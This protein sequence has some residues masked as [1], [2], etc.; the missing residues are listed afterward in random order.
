M[1]SSVPKYDLTTIQ[2]MIANGEY[3][4]TSSAMRDAAI[5]DYDS[6]EIK[7]IVLSLRTNNFYKSMPSHKNEMIW[8]DVYHKTIKE[9]GVTLYIKLQIVKDAIIISFKEK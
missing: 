2:T 8:Q 3:R 7:R 4:I 6:K 9:D 5:I 1:R